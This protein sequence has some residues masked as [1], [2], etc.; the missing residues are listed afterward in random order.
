VEVLISVFVTD[1]KRV[2][3]YNGYEK[4]LLFCNSTVTVT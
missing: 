4:Q 1:I 3:D 2:T